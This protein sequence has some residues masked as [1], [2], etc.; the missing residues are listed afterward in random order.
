MRYPQFSPFTRIFL[1]FQQG[2]QPIPALSAAEL[3]TFERQRKQRNVQFSAF[4]SWAIFA[5]EL[6][7]FI[8]QTIRGSYHPEWDYIIIGFPLI[9]TT[10]FGIAIFIYYLIIQHLSVNIQH[11]FSLTI[12]IIWLFYSAVED[13]VLLKIDQTVQ[14][15]HLIGIL[16][17]YAILN[18]K[19]SE[20]VFSL[21]ASHLTYIIISIFLGNSYEDR[22]LFNFLAIALIS[23]GFRDRYRKSIDDFYKQITIEKQSLQIQ[24]QA[25]LLN[26][27]NLHLQDLDNFKTRLYTNITH[28]FRTPLTVIL[29][30][31]KLV[32]EKPQEWLAEGVDTITRNGKQLLDLVNQMLDLSRLESGSMPLHLQQGNII[33]FLSYLAQSFQSFA[34]S[35][36]IQLHFTSEVNECI[37]DFDAD[38]LTK[39]VSNL[40]SNAVKYTPESGHIKLEVRS[41]RYDTSNVFRASHLE[42]IV[43]DTGTGI[44]EAQLP[45]IFDRFYQVDDSQTRKGEGTGIG[46]ALTKEFVQLMQGTISVES[47]LDKGT[48]FTLSLPI[49][50]TASSLVDSAFA[51]A[52]PVVD[53]SVAP[54][55]I[56]ENDAATDLPLALI[57][58]DN[59]DVVQYLSACLKNQ[60][61]LEVAFD[62]AAG[63]KKAITIVPDIII[64]DVMMPEK[65]GFKV[66][67]TLK[68]DIRTSHIPIILLTAKADKASRI[69]G[70]EH[71]ADVYLEKPFEKEE[72]EVRLRK[73]IELRAHLRQ[74]YQLADLEEVTPEKEPD[75]ELLFLKQLHSVILENIANED[76]R[77]EPD[78][79]RAMTMSRPQLYRKIKALKDQSPS[80]YVRSIRMQQARHLLLHTDF[81]IGDIAQ[82]VGFKEHSYFTQVYHA[83]FG[84]T[85]LE[86][87]NS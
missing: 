30:M 31:T 62:G 58:E 25:F 67:A 5:F 38:K 12:S 68:H 70:L 7:Q 86:T 22:F 59:Q 21:L 24:Q 73:L 19:L 2:K 47:Q 51:A 57:I 87:R 27:Q 13:S 65:D 82:Q 74:K 11:S 17:M 41:T 16:L 20:I 64:S 50:R 35:K 4:M 29:G 56:V 15:T 37:M 45:F 14:N 69:E 28:E 84:E 8:N 33:H 78:L 72:L 63:I 34:A 39:V 26:E 53:L 9:S 77:V 79:C 55:Y 10:I 66:C 85:P 40:I 43:T 61:Q 71:G 6:I 23:R 3:A 18:Y 60:Y 81:H 83:T 76:F 52:Q 75:Q 1:Y 44:P 49:K 48:T 46:L 80:E 36:N 32:K 42:F 54:E